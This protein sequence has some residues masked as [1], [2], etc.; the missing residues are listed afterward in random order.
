VPPPEA[1]HPPSSGGGYRG[2][3]SMPADDSSSDSQVAVCS[4]VR[5]N[6]AH[7]VGFVKNCQRLNVA[8]TRARHALVGGASPVR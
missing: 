8:L 7:R 4:F 5:S 6:R 1:Q 2:V 3:P